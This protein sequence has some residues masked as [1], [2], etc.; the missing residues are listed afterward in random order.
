[1]SKDIEL[2]VTNTGKNDAT[3]NMQIDSDQLPDNWT[4][5]ALTPLENISIDSGQSWSPTLRISVPSD[6]LGSD[7]GSILLTLTPNESPNSTY[8]VIIPIEANRTRGISLRGPM[9]IAQTTGWGIPGS[10]A[11]A[12]IVIENLG[13]AQ[14]TDTGITY[15]NTITSISLGPGELQIL[16]L[17][18]AVPSTTQLGDNVSSTVEICIGSGSERECEQILVDFIAS[19]VVAI[20]SHHRTVPMNGIEWQIEG[21]FTSS[22]RE[23]EWDLANGGLSIQSDWILNCTGDLEILGDKL[24]ARSSTNSFSGSIILDLP[25][26]PCRS[27][28]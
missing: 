3:W 6:A 24:F 26:K 7:E 27:K 5:N 21:I 10:T 12:W 1:M 8:T 9:G 28:S 15:G 23:M 14:E 2:L 17:E 20:P 11:H 18:I 16:S 22:D 4:V 13:N 19:D 25:A